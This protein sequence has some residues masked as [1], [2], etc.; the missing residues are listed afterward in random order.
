MSSF[1]S[2][3]GAGEDAC[4]PPDH[5]VLHVAKT[6]EE[7]GLPAEVEVTPKHKAKHKVKLAPVVRQVMA[8]LKFGGKSRGPAGIVEGE[9]PPITEEL[10]WKCCPR[11]LWVSAKYRH[12]WPE[13]LVHLG[14]LDLSH[15]K[16]A[17][18]AD[19]VVWLYCL[20]GAAHYVTMPNQHYGSISK[21]PL[22][23]LDRRPC[24]EPREHRYLYPH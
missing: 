17:G 23:F 9:V 1:S 10:A 12:L 14:C 5:P 24:E 11:L 4:Q 3:Q 16:E 6:F 7:M 22:G 19:P 2:H 21:V 15:I 8:F 18:S 13:G 20:D